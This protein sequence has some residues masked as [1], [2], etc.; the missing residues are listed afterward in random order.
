MYGVGKQKLKIA[1]SIYKAI[2]FAHVMVDDRAVIP[3]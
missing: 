1:V 3:S 2:S